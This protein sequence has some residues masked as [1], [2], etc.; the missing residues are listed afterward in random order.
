M[1]THRVNPALIGGFVIGAVAL[2]VGAVLVLGGRNWFAR[3]ITCVMA[4]DG[5]VAGLSAGAPVRFRGVQLG[6]VTDIQFRYGT[7]RILVVSAFD[8]SRVK[9]LHPDVTT[10]EA[11]RIVREGVGK[12][13]RAQ[14]QLQSLITGQL[15]VGLDFYPETSAAIAENNGPCEIPTVPTTLAQVQ[16]QMKKLLTDLDQL[17]LKQSVEAVMRAA[18]A[19]EKIASAPEIPR[20]LGSADRTLHET[21]T[22][23]HNLNTKVDPVVGNLQATLVRTQRTFDDVGGDMRRLLHDV[24]ARVAPLAESIG[25][26]ADSVQAL[27]TDG[28]STLHHLDTEIA[29]TMAA[30]RGAG[31]AVHDAM[32]Q[33]QTVLGHADGFLDGD[34]ALGYRLAEAL[35]EVTRTARAL[36]GLSEEVERQPNLLLF[37]RGGTK[38][39]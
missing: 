4:F 32:Q 23:V 27:M 37:G 33:A 20:V 8:P 35:D 18:S 1:M 22:L 5:S 38:N 9:G 17:P 12:G 31:D 16:D 25:S 36:R 39:K 15:Y 30:L 26:A 28:R 3:P 7:T 21:A 14:L 13:L 19:I 2:T 24:D 34:S 10:G 11:G 29:P 6:T